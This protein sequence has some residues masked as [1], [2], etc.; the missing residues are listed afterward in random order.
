MTEVFSYVPR[1]PHEAVFVADAGPQARR[2]SP[3]EVRDRLAATHGVEIVEGVR[4][5]VATGSAEP[6]GPDGP[7]ASSRHLV[8][9][10]LV[11][12]RDGSAVEWI[13]D[14]PR[15]DT[16]LVAFVFALSMGNGAA[17]PQPTGAFELTVADVVTIAFTITK[18]PKRWVREGASLYFEPRRIDT[19]VWGASYSLDE[20]IDSESTFVDGAAVVVL[21]RAMLRSRRPPRF[22]LAGVGHARSRR[23][24]RVGIGQQLGLADP[25]LALVETALGEEE[26]KSALGRRVV[27]GDIHNHSGESSLLEELPDGVGAD[28]SCGI[29]S[30]ESLFR[31][32]RDVAGL[33]FFCLSEH[34]W[35]MSD[36]DWSSLNEMTDGWNSA[37][38]GFVTLHGYEWTSAAYGHRNVYFRDAPSSLFYSAPYAEEQNVIRD[39]LP[40]PEDLWRFLDGQPRVAMT[41]PHHMSVRFFPLS[42][43]RFNSSKYDRV[44]EIYSSWGDSLEPDQ[45]VSTSAQRVAELAFVEALKD[46]HRLGFI[47]SSDSHDGHPGNAQGT[48]HRRQLFHFLGSGLAGVLVEQAERSAIFD[49]LHGRHCAAATSEGLM[50][51]TEVEGQLM[52]SRVSSRRTARAPRVRIVAEAALPL[53]EVTIFK[54]GRRIETIPFG[55]DTRTIDMEWADDGFSP[56]AS[57]SYFVK[58]V[59]GDQEM[60]WSS[61][62]W[63]DP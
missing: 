60:A 19:A 33:D 17:F 43:D 48:H 18:T 37:D 34:D 53:Q 54:D 49:G 40:T 57:T 39:G 47:G 13:A 44:A 38:G 55:P 35:Q 51:A 2:L 58:V 21:P 20:L 24:S 1:Q 30:R 31:Y 61:P 26:Q 7:I 28:E 32:A 10:H 12:E 27:F 29:G 5:F 14:V 16:P 59:R 15:L 3:T 62:L 42:L 45:P 56:D 11:R 22:R 9:A 63:M 23:W 8:E 52:G 41:V 46:G 36:G 50:V 25:V 4:R 6:Y